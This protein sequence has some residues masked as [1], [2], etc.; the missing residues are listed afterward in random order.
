MSILVA[1]FHRCDVRIGSGKERNQRIDHQTAIT[2]RIDS[3]NEAIDALLADVAAFQRVVDATLKV[4]I[5]DPALMPTNSKNSSVNM[6]EMRDR[7][8]S[9]VLSMALTRSTAPS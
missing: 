3:A 4:S 7:T 5:S 2:S 1:A 8:N 9:H 6:K